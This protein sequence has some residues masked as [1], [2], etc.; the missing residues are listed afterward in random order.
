MEDTEAFLNA[1]VKRAVPPTAFEVDAALKSAMDL[2]V[3]A[4]HGYTL[5]FTNKTQATLTNVNNATGC[6][7]FVCCC[8]NCY[9]PDFTWDVRFENG[10]WLVY[11]RLGVCYRIM[12]TPPVCLH[13]IAPEHTRVQALV[14][15]L[16]SS[17]S[18]PA[19]KTMARESTPLLSSLVG[20]AR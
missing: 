11:D 4:A 6:R 17:Y 9:A 19:A 8:C 7:A 18:A 14:T 12:F 2:D 1:A 10:A 3:L 5:E 15:Q 16:K 20:L 13:T